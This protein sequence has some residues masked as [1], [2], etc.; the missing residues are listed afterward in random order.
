[1]LNKS[2]IKK[3]DNS[4]LQFIFTLHKAFIIANVDEHKHQL[5]KASVNIMP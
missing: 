1:M 5:C 3:T 4:F 2:N